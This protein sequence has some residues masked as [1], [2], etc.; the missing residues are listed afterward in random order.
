MFYIIMLTIRSWYKIPNDIELAN[1]LNTKCLC[2][3]DPTL[4]M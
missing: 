2:E 1:K 4:Y 3:S